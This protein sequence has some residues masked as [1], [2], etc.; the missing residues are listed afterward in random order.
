M[1][2]DGLSLKQGTGGELFGYGYLALPLSDAP[3]APDSNTC[4]Y[5]WNEQLV[6]KL[7][8]KNGPLV[9]LPQYYHLVK[10]NNRKPEWIVVQPEMCP[11][12]QG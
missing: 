6:S 4:G 8:S 11:L 9:M 7:D 5:E 3:A 10:D 12:K 1:A 2:P